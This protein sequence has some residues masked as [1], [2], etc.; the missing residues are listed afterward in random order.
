MIAFEMAKLTQERIWTLL[1]AESKED[2]SSWFWNCHNST[3]EFPGDLRQWLLL[4]QLIMLFCK[5]DQVGY[6]IS[7]I[8]F[9]LWPGLN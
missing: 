1:A 9:L 4:S 5:V 3:S 2:V 6:I 8:W 7:V